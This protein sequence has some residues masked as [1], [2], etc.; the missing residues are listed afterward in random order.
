MLTRGASISLLV[1][2]CTVG[3]T[4][5]ELRQA[6]LVD[7]V[8]QDNL[9]WLSR[10]TSLLEAK[11]HVMADDPYDYMRGTATVFFRDLARA[12]TERLATEFLTD[13]EATSILI[14]GDPH[15]ENTGTFLPGEGPGPVDGDPVL[16]LE[17]NDLDAAG[18]GPYVLDVRRA[19]LGTAVLLEQGGCG[20]ACRAEVLTTWASAYVHEIAAPSFRPGVVLGQHGVVFDRLM[21]DVVEEGLGRE[22]IRETTEIVQGSRRFRLDPGLDEDGDGILRVTPDERARIERVLAD[23]PGP[24]GFRVLDVARRYGGGVAS[25][26]AFRFVVAWDRGDDGPDDD[27]LLQVREVVDPPSL[28]GLRA[29]GPA[30]FDSNGSRVVEASTTLW[31]RPDVDVRLASVRDG[32]MTFKVLTWSAFNESQD[33]AKITR[34]MLRGRML[35]DDLVVW[36]ELMGRHLAATHARGF[37]ANGTRALEA[38]RRDLGDRGEAFVAERTREAETDLAAL[39]DDHELFVDALE[40]FGPLLGADRLD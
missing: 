40:R 3:S 37:T 18:F 20:E 35:Q 34:D 39:L 23:Y 38:I 27:E 1:A 33:H 15:P 17:V 22:R 10:D 29:T 13:V 14:V 11:Y 28:P 26:P 8:V 31:S 16:V 4:P 32:D 25:M 36:A 6:W 12:G 7:A 24:E 30:L 2:G 19:L 5:D 9:V 21:N